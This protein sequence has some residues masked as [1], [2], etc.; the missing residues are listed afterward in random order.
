MK[1]AWLGVLAFI[2][3]AAARGDDKPKPKETPAERL[4]AI[5]KA[6]KA[7]EA[8]YFKTSE[9][10]PDTPEG[11][12]KQEEVTK[13]YN[14]GQSAR[15]M[16]ALEIAKAAPKSD[17]GFAALEWLLTIPRTYFLPAGKP[18]MEL[19]TKYHAENPKIGKVIAWVGYYR[20]RGVESEAAALALIDAVAKKNP[21]RNARAQAVMA[22]AW[23]AKDKFAVAERKKSPDADKLAAEAE[24]AF[25]AV[26]KDY[27]DSPRL[28]R[29]GGAPLGEEAKLELFELRHLR[30][31]KTAPDIAG[32]DL[33]GAKF[34]LSDYRGKVVVLD[35][36][37]DW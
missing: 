19:M 11:N 1:R 14:K 32:D 17:A 37:G 22:Q 3:V 10:I 13:A 2:V 20:P 34:K 24:K 7:A 21:D 33:D 8:E 29:A 23:Q 36:W 18:A 9:Q 27:A 31:G 12:K 30:V 28:L 15:F 16:E 26:I 25:E 6:H 4:A 35:F 5:Q